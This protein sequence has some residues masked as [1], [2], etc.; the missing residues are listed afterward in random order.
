M[1]AAAGGNGGGNDGG[2]TGESGNG[3]GGGGEEGSEGEPLRLPWDCASHSENSGARGSDCAVAPFC[4]WLRRSA[5]VE[6]AALAPSPRQQRTHCSRAQSHRPYAASTA[7]A[8]E[9][10]KRPREGEN[11]KPVVGCTA[12]Q[13]R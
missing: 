7:S 1:A 6:A 4:E 12:I 13:T 11:S 10:T 8:G 5:A 2:G 9:K 3:E